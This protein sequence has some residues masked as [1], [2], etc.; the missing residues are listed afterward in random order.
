MITHYLRNRCISV[1]HFLKNKVTKC[2]TAKPPHHW[3][4]RPHDVTDSTLKLK[5]FA[6]T[7]EYFQPVLCHCFWLF[8]HFSSTGHSIWVLQ[9]SILW[10][11]GRH[12][13]TQDL[14]PL[15]TQRMVSVVP[16][17]NNSQ[18]SDRKHQRWLIKCLNMIQECNL[19]SRVRSQP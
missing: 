13:T 5:R 12:P 7:N 19:K 16:A 18:G 9:R 8:L 17:A 6:S 15:N 10:A 1:V 14:V 4:K 11:A 2:F 3:L